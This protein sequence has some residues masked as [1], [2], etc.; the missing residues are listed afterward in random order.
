VDGAEAALVEALADPAAR[1]AAADGLVRRGARSVDALA[2]ALGALDDEEALRAAALALGRIGSPAAVPALLALLEAG[3][4]ATIAVAGA[5]GAIGDR[6]AFEPLVRQ[7]AVGALSSI[8]HPGLRERA[9]ALLDSSSAAVRESA[10][11]IAAYFGYE[12]CLD[13]LLALC[14]DDDESVRRA[15]VEHLVCLDDPRVGE[16]LGEALRS[17]TGPTRAAAARALARLEPAAAAALLPAALADPDLWVRYYAARSA[18]TLG[19]ADLGPALAGLARGDAAVPVRI[20]ALQALGTAGAAEAV[21]T[22]AALAED[23]EPE[24]RLAALAVLGGSAEPEALGALG[25]ALRGDDAEAQR[26]ALD[27]LEGE[28][29]AALAGEAAGAARATRD[30]ETAR[31]AAFA[32]LRAASPEAV[33]LLCGL[34]A[35]PALRDPC[36]EVLARLPAERLGLLADA[37]RETDAAGR[38]A[39]LAALAHMRGGAA[40]RLAASL[41]DDPSPGVRRAAEHA[42]CR[43]DLRA[44][45]VDG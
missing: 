26:A 22:A 35:E 40:A 24:V 17:G 18:G 45:A 2:A 4:D 32:L 12:E 21:A 44:A 3:S 41:V 11:R 14:G 20:A 27:A 39:A 19:L 37:L 34:A 13:R 6:R 33:R 5:L 36:V 28:A 10:A 29:A 15:A 25:A 16:V 23:G 38:E 43:L 8:A 42:L 7:A 30:P 31:A 9:A 1:G